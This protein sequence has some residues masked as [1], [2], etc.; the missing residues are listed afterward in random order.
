MLPLEAAAA[1]EVVVEE[2]EVPVEAV[3]EVGVAVVVGDEDE[4][5]RCGRAAWTT[6]HSEHA[7]VGLRSFHRTAT[8]TILVRCNF[9]G[10]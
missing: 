2:G 3:E 5:S 6:H 4:A 10:G 7:Q 1:V 8:K 9:G